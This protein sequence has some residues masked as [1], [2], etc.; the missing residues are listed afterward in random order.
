[1]IGILIQTLRELFQEPAPDPTAPSQG[2]VQKLLGEVRRCF[3][4][5]YY[6]LLLVTIGYYW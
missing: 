1:M 5:G 2:Q 4:I 3:V 6:W